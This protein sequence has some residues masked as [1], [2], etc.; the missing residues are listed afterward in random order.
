[1]MDAFQALAAGFG[2]PG[3]GS[4]E[5]LKAAAAGIEE[6]SIRKPF[7]R[8]VE[9]VT[10]LGLEGWEELHTRTLDLSPVLVPYVGYAIWEDNYQRG[11]FLSDMQRAEREAGV[12]PHGELPDHLD[13]VLRYLAVAPEPIPGLLEILPQ[14]LATMSKNLKKA[15]SANPYRFLLEAIAAV[16]IPVGGAA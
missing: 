13:P 11:A 14:A 1:M 2:Y 5:E 7:T 9:K 12:D 3:P 16:P 8:F 6:A 4:I 15:E 10:A